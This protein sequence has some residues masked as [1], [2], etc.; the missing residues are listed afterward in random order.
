MYDR[1]AGCLKVANL[2]QGKAPEEI[3]ELLNIENDFSEEEKVRL[4]VCSSS[5]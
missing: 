5:S 3:R 4:R 2:I 1:N